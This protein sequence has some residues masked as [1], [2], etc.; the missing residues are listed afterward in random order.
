M[1]IKNKLPE[2]VQVFEN[3]DFMSKYCQGLE[4]YL[5]TELRQKIIQIKTSCR[6]SKILIKCIKV[7]LDYHK[8]QNDFF[9]ELSQLDRFFASM[10][11]KFDKSFTHMV[12]H[13][14]FYELDYSR[15]FDSYFNEVFEDYKL[16]INKHFTQKMLELDDSTFT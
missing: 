2:T 4:K 13:T 6:P 10:Y 15:H 9:N 8:S 7:I 3:I 12:R 1:N 5:N 14:I 16:N 11:S